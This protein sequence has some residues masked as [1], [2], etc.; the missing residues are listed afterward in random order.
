MG[1]AFYQRRSRLR[2]DVVVFEDLA[3]LALLKKFA[4]KLHSKFQ[5]EQLARTAVGYFI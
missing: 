5:E 2:H 1:G 4:K 3:F